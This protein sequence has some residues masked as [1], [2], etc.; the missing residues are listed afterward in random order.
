MKNLNSATF[1][2]NTN[3]E[4]IPSDLENWFNNTNNCIELFNSLGFSLLTDEEIIALQNP[5]Q[6][7]FIDDATYFAVKEVLPKMLFVAK[8]SNN[9][10]FGYSLLGSSIIEAPIITFN[11]DY[12]DLWSG[13]LIEA[14]LIELVKEDE[15]AYNKHKQAF[16]KYD[17][18]IRDFQKLMEEEVTIFDNYIDPDDQ[19]ETLKTGKDLR[20]LAFNTSQ[21]T[22]LEWQSPRFGTENPT[23]IDSEHWKSCIY[24]KEEAYAIRKKY[25]GTVD[26]V[27]WC[28]SRLGQ[29]ITR[30][31]DKEIYIAGE[32]EDFYDPDFNI[33]N[34]VVVIN[35]DNSIEIYNYPKA[36][37]PS[38]DFHSA[39]LINTSTILIVGSLGY[40]KDRKIGITPIYALNIENFRIEKI[41]TKGE[42]PGW[43]Y[44][45]RAILSD[46]KRFLK[47]VGGEIISEVELENIDE[48]Q[49]D[50]QSFKWTRLTH[51]K[52]KRWRF[53]RKDKKR[54]Q[55]W[56][57]RQA[58]YNLN[59]GKG[60]V[61][62]LQKEFGYDI[63]VSKAIELYQFKDINTYKELPTN[64]NEYNVYRI[65]V[66]NVTI[67]FVESSYDVQATIE[68]ELNNDIMEKIQETILQK[69]S[70][71]ENCD[72]IMEKY[73]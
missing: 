40:Y 37:F 1:K 7:D 43:I 23:N 41:L 50:L 70:K 21:Q 29:S 57:I 38:T 58:W 51:K 6:L 16:A 3:S 55:L 8:N 69:V 73:Y 15:K 53:Q 19:V 28:F 48:W 30:V 56:K 54:N 44:K 11:K 49:L 65:C 36:D 64:S 20:H 2:K 66:N 68:G 31:N 62:A 24:S 13:N 34:D 45:H 33:Y 39:T 67:K 27:S 46:D 22:F 72:Y 4:Q 59:R 42:S 32:H 63:D 5:N 9:V 25:N 47:I 61:K 35:S 18:H 52:W 17:L 14:L 10:Y 71:L 60:D 12:F 26:K